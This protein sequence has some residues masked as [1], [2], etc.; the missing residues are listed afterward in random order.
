MFSKNRHTGR[1]RLTR[2]WSTFELLIELFILEPFVVVT[3]G[4]QLTYTIRMKCML[5]IWNVQRDA[6]RAGAV[7]VLKRS[8]SIFPQRNSL[9]K[10][11][12]NGA[13]LDHQ[14]TSEFTLYTKIPG[15]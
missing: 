4:L 7:A 9:V 1:I 5:V 15:R 3:G 12:K 13:F 6:S 2:C 8:K 11:I 14:N 10:S